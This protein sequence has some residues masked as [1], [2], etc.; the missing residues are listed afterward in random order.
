MPEPREL[1]EHS[2]GGRRVVVLADPGHGALH[3]AHDNMQV[4]WEHRAVRGASAA[5]ALRELRLA[6]EPGRGRGE[7]GQ[8][9]LHQRPLEQHHW[10]LR[11]TLRRRDHHDLLLVALLAPLR[12]LLLVV[13]PSVLPAPTARHAPNQAEQNGQGHDPAHHRH[14][15][16]AQMLPPLAPARRFP[17]RTPCILLSNLSMKWLRWPPPRRCRVLREHQ[18]RIPGVHERR[19]AEFLDGA[20]VHHAGELVVRD[21]Q[22]THP[23]ERR[24]VP[25]EP[26]LHRVPGQVEP[27]YPRQPPQTLWHRPDPVRRHVEPAE[28]REP[29]DACDAGEAV[30][31]HVEGLEPRVRLDAERAAEL[32]SGDVHGAERR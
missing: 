28:P 8:R 21:V 4:S 29:V 11:G 1:P 17:F 9:E 19:V 15:H 3:D 13:L 7:V 14:R 18:R 10:R 23:T 30:T 12:L 31:G 26:P 25:G 22:E 16:D 24:Q 32:V 2:G 5:T 27:S 20:G 6:P